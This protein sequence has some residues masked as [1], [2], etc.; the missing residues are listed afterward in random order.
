MYRQ[1]HQVRVRSRET[2]RFAATVRLRNSR[3][4]WKV[5]A[6]PSCETRCGGAPE[7]AFSPSRTWP[8]DGRYRP[9]ITLK[10]VVFPEPF[11]PTMPSISP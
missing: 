11:G 1:L 5:R 6:T 4:C 2:S 7:M 9:L 8:A 3:R 10:S